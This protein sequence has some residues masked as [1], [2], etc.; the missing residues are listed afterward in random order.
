MALVCVII[1]LLATRS[2]GRTL[3]VLHRLCLAINYYSGLRPQTEFGQQGSGS[4]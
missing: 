2:E 1:A 4:S 3:T